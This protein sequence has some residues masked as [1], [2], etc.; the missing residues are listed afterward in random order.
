MSADARARLAALQA[1]L[2]AALA[3]HAA[4]PTGFDAERIRAAAAALATKRRRA[5]ARAWPGLTAA[6]AEHFDSYAAATPLPRLGGPLADGRAFLRWL[7]AR[8][9]Y[10]HQTRLQALA[11]DLRYATTADGLVP[12]RGPML[13]AAWLRSTRRLVMALRLPWLGEWWV[14]VPLDW[15][16]LWRARSPQTDV[17]G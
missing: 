11:V 3:G 12:R 13:K 14:S 6:I 16:G 17:S 2:V 1:E 5:M 7:A 15:R 8:A 10:P 9:E 4:P